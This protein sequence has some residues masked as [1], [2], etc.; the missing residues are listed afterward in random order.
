MQKVNIQQSGSEGVIQM[1]S[2]TIHVYSHGLVNRLRA[3]H[4]TS[5]SIWAHVA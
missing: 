3:E 1:V 5:Q 4:L 2:P